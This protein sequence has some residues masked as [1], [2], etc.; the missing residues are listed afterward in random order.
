ASGGNERSS[1]AASAN[2]FKK[3]GITKQTGFQR[4]NGR[5]SL[6]YKLSEAATLSNKTM[7]SALK[8]EGQLEGGGYYGSPTY[9]AYGMRPTIKAFNSDGSPNIDLPTSLFNPI[10]VGRHDINKTLAYNLL[11]NT[12]LKLDLLD[13]LDFTSV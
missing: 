7:F 10:W 3:D 9:T 5:L 13:N 6:G 2:Y 11:N 4:M 1:F 8:Q 12:R